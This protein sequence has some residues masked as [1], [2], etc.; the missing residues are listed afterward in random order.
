MRNCEEVGVTNC[1]PIL[2]I[3]LCCALLLLGGREAFEDGVSKY[4]IV[5]V[6]VRYPLK[7]NCAPTF[8]SSY[9]QPVSGK[10]FL[11]KTRSRYDN[12]K[13]LFFEEMCFRLG[14]DRPPLLTSSV[15]SAFTSHCTV[16]VLYAYFMCEEAVKVAVV[17]VQK[18]FAGGWYFPGCEN[19]H[20]DKACA[21][22]SYSCP[23]LK[24]KLLF[25]CLWGMSH[26]LGIQKKINLSELLLWGQTVT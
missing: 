11:A 12:G 17:P 8:S 7:G 10:Y 14:G 16:R 23:L 1:H 6:H 21:H 18:C 19:N 26:V 5:L 4:L 22:V 9:S 24:Q 3:Y 20:Q 2:L 25:A 15:T 13:L